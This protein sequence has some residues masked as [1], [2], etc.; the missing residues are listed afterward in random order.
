VADLRTEDRLLYYRE[1]RRS[2]REAIAPL[3][4]DVLA[5]DELAT[6]DRLLVG[7]VTVDESG[8]ALSAEFGARV[9]RAIHGTDP[10]DTVTPGQFAELRRHSVES[11]GPPERQRALADLELEYLDRRAEIVRRVTDELADA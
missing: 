5:I 3:V 2:L 11:P 7:L 1:I 6:I 8:P 9:H 10:A 4:D